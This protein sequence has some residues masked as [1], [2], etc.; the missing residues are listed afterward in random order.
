[1]RF[2]LESTNFN[3]HVGH[4]HFDKPVANGYRYILDA[5]FR[6]VYRLSPALSRMMV[7]WHGQSRCLNVHQSESF[8]LGE[9]RAVQDD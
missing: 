8:P 6:S 2:P 3:D 4:G 5:S 1:M 7:D 9:Q